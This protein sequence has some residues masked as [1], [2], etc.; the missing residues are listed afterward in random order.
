M[1][2]LL[3]LLAFEFLPIAFAETVS[4]CFEHGCSSVARVDFDESELRQIRELFHEGLD[5]AREREGIAQ[6]VS[7]LEQITGGRIGTAADRGGTGLVWPGQMDCIDEAT[8]STT[9]LSLLS[10]LGLLRWHT[11]AEPATRGWL[12]FGW[13]HTTAVVHE[14]VTGESFAVDS[15]FFDNGIFPVIIP[16]HTW[17][18]GWTP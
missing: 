7:L 11:V 3:F 9:Y 10:R 17:Q 8:N 2:V 1:R 12:L 5:A 6:A 16:L 18:Q 4:I 15:W 14:T 13:P